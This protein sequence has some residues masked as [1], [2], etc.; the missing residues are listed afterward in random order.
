MATKTLEILVRMRDQLSAE[1]RGSSRAVAEHGRSLENLQTQYRAVERVQREA[2]RSL[3]SLDARRAQLVRE[4]RLNRPD[5]GAATQIRDAERERRRLADLARQAGDLGDFRQEAQIRASLE[6]VETRIYRLRREQSEQTQRQRAAAAE[7][8]TVDQQRARVLEQQRQTET[9]QARLNREKISTERQ[10]L[11]L[12]RQQAREEQAAAAASRRAAVRGVGNAFVAGGAAAGFNPL[13]GVGVYSL[14]ASGAGAGAIAAGG[15]AAAAGAGMVAATAV[16]IDF[17]HAMSR[18][19][20]LTNATADEFEALEARA[21]ELGAKTVFTARQAAESMQQFA[22]A[23]FDANKILAASGPALDLAAAGQ[24]S[25]AEA[26]Q[27]VVRIMAGMGVQTHEVASAVDVLVKAFTTSNTDLRELGDAM[28]FVGPIARLTGQD[29][30]ETAAAIQVLSDAG[31]AGELAGTGLRTVLLSLANPSGPAA[32]AMKEL[33]FNVQTARD[34]M[35]RLGI[36]V[37]DAHGNFLPLADI[38]EQF[39]KSLAGMGSADQLEYIGKIFPNRAA[40]AMATLIQSG[41]ARLREREAALAPAASAGTAERVAT[42]QLDNTRGAFM[43]LQGAAESA[44]INIGDKFNPAVRGVLDATTIAL[45]GVNALIDGLEDLSTHKFSEGASFAD[46]ARNTVGLPIRAASWTLNQHKEEAAARQKIIELQKTQ[47][48]QEWQWIQMQDAQRRDRAG[49][50]IRMQSTGESFEDALS[51][52]RAEQNAATNARSAAQQN[53]SELLAGP[54]LSDESNEVMGD[55]KK[56]PELLTQLQTALDEIGTKEAERREELARQLATTEQR[57]TLEKQLKDLAEQRRT[58]ETAIANELVKQ[59]DAKVEAADAARAGVAEASRQILQATGGD[60]DA[61]RA[62]GL[63]VA[64]QVTSQISA[65]QKLAAD[66]NTPEAD[67]RLLQD[68]ANELSRRLPELQRL[69]EEDVALQQQRAREDLDRGRGQFFDDAELQ[70]LRDKAA[71]GIGDVSDADVQRAEIRAE[72]ARR[73]QER[74][75]FIR[76]EDDR[77]RELRRTIDNPA[78]SDADRDQARQDLGKSEDAE[79]RA[80]S[81]GAQLDQMLQARLE[82]VEGSAGTVQGFGNSTAAQQ[83]VGFGA[84][85]KAKPE[86][87][88]AKNTGDIKN[89]QRELIGAIGLLVEMVK[90]NGGGLGGVGI[91]NPN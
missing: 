48:D 89:G 6:G 66:P 52:V 5:T 33:G 4:A 84:P 74:E 77:Q 37:R 21:I 59:R 46:V 70:I 40:G 19:K 18:V 75:Q 69:A 12:K 80:I 39:E 58:V 45:R 27:I 42:T 1:M 44:G 34:E 41:S 47:Q 17:E 36:T 61:Q 71:S 60:R 26:S 53:L 9:A 51:A 23:G 11:Q 91:F 82:A 13:A 8:A 90:Q 32:D 14:A 24:L 38:V 63:G 79:R 3:A 55:L 88:T 25:M 7:L 35:E 30:H 16:T 43:E 85:D 65:L 73:Q 49:A 57:A 67:E 81:L 64:D 54:R 10:I 28:K 31:M 29:L 62:A 68:I 87:E 56:D 15:L 76:N 20:A 22:L 50:R 72:F 83:F 78:T 86:E 2:A